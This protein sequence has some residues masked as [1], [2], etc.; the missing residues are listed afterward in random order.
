MSKHIKNDIILETICTAN[1]D[2]F[3]YT[4]YR[5]DKYASKML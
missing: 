1:V 4:L 5:I 2:N 3:I